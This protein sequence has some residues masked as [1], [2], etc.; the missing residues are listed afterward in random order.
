[1][2]NEEILERLEEIERGLRLMVPCLVARSREARERFVEEG[3]TVEAAG[4]LEEEMGM[5]FA[6]A[7]RLR[8]SALAEMVRE[9]DARQAA[10][11]LVALAQVAVGL[12]DPASVRRFERRRFARARSGGGS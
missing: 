1:M 6:D 12:G 7:N 5:V 8:A 10:A 4:A 9:M 11:Y 3:L 2:E